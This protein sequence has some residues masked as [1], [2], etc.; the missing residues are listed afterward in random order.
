VRW[1]VL[2]TALAAAGC[3]EDTLVRCGDLVC[4]NGTSCVA[5]RC[6]TPAQLEACA[7]QPDGTVCSVD[8]AVGAC[9]VGICDPTGCGNAHLD[10]GEVCDDGNTEYGDGCSG[11][12]RSQEACGNGV[13]DFAVGETCDCGSDETTRPTTCRLANSES[14]EAECTTSCALRYCGNDVLDRLEQCDGNDVGAAA[15][16]DFGYYAGELSCLGACRYDT[17]SCV[18]R[19]GDGTVDPVYGEFCDGAP[20]EGTCLGYG[21]DAGS[22]G[23]SSTCTPGTATCERFGWQ[24]VDAVAPR[25][26]WAR[27]SDTLMIASNSASAWITIGSLREMAPTGTYRVAT[28]IVGGAAFAV[29][30]TTI[31]IWDGAQWSS[32]AAG[33]ST[34]QPTAA[35]ASATLG[36]FVV[37]NNTVWRHDGTSWTDQQLTGIT[38][39]S[40]DTTNVYAWSTTAVSTSTGGPWNAVA[41]P[42][43][44]GTI[45]AFGSGT[46]ARWLGVN[47]SSV[48]RYKAGTWGKD[49]T[50]EAFTQLVTTPSGDVILGPALRRM[51]ADDR[52]SDRIDGPGVVARIAQ[53]GFDDGILVTTT[54]TTWRL[55]SGSWARNFYIW[56]STYLADATRAH[57]GSAGGKAIVAG[58]IAWYA[59]PNSDAFDFAY[60]MAFYFYDFTETADA[61][62][63]YA[64]DEYGEYGLW[65]YDADANPVLAV[66][67][68]YRQ[69]RNV[70]SGAVVAAGD[71]RLARGGLPTWDAGWVTYDLPAYN[72]IVADERNDGSYV[73][74]AKRTSDNQYVLLEITSSGTATEIAGTLRAGSWADV[75]LA[76]DDT[77][78]AVSGTTLAVAAPGAAITTNEFPGAI[79]ETVGGTDH[80]DVFVGGSAVPFSGFSGLAHYDGVAWTSVRPATP[81]RFLHVTDTLISYTYAREHITLQRVIRW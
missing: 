11:D 42:D 31:A 49:V 74:S 68:I 61:K 75:W 34:G 56:D 76:P 20:P 46:D 47:N 3:I 23:C 80:D 60:P 57:F 38:G 26:L 66:A 40:G 41:L 65:G 29:G 1:L 9:S 78:Y 30:D 70:R 59:P 6:A 52:P 81:V 4:P 21:Y 14:L 50:V 5:D 45:T 25:S 2:A 37:V 48:F 24:I 62:F 54:T 7:G 19:C 8:S 67:G 15:C 72:V 64:T 51:F 79:L 28:G 35:W 71:G 36:L 73:A 32:L 33:W 55:R 27:G 39:V 63:V 69:L 53:S 13:V 12:C 22:L 16:S 10:S 58:T 17:T 43:F 18:G 44:T 77:L